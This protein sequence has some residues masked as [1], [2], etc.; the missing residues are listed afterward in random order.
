MS[1]FDAVLPF[2]GQ[3]RASLRLLLQ[4]AWEAFRNFSRKFR[5]I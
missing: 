2:G 5:V 3:R 4:D 1:L